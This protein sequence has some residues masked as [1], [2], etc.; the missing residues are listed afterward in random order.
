M[1]AVDVNGITIHHELHG[2]P[3]GPPILVISGSGGDLRRTFPDRSPLNEAGRTCHFDQ[4]GLGQTSKPPGPYT[5]IGYADDAA[6]LARSLGWSRC[7]VVGTSFGG[8]VALE[9]VARHPDLVD[10]LVLNCTSPGGEWS[11]FPLD[12]LA[13]LP[14]E[15]RITRTMSLSDSRFDPQTDPPMPG[16]SPAAFAA[17]AA[18]ARTE[19]TGDDLAGYLAQLQARLTHD[20]NDR[21]SAITSPTLVC[22][23]RYDQIAPLANAQRLAESIPDARLKVFDGGHLFM[24]QDRT[25]YPVMCDFLTALSL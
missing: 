16:F 4:R 19:R 3:D 23:G 15:E 9:L 11:S 24:L 14:L 21:L 22:A 17:Y 7:H 6:A 18:G 10:R 2:D 13:T 12:T 5:M 8:M 1:P 20:V 25:A